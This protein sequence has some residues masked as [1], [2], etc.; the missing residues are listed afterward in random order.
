MDFYSYEYL[1][2]NQDNSRLIKLIVVGLLVVIIGVFFFLYMRNRFEIKY[3]DLGIIFATTLLLVI[4][5]QY[6]DYS[7]LLTTQKQTGQITGTI[8]ETAKQ[9]GVKPKQVSVNSTTQTDGLLV[10]TPKG[11]FRIDFNTDGSSFLL[12][13]IELHNP[14]IN[15]VRR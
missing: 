14:K 11:F 9:L 8:K 5:I 13:K 12:E 7:N 2:S 3:K 6:N 15:V 1:I 4:A 10:N